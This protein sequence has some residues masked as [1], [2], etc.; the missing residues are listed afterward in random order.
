MR[1]PHYLLHSLASATGTN[2]RWGFTL[3][4]LDAGDTIA[5][6]EIEAEASSERLELLSVVRGLEALPEPAQVTLLT[7]SDTIRRGIH[8]GL[9]EWRDNDWQWESFGEMVPV[10]NLDLW[11]RIDRA[12]SYHDVEVRRWRVDPAQGSADPSPAA[13]EVLAHVV[14][15]SSTVSQPAESFADETLDTPQL[16]QPV[17]RIALPEPK[18]IVVPTVTALPD[19]VRRYRTR[20]WNSRRHWQWYWLRLRRRIIELWDS[21]AWMCEQLRGPRP[22]ADWHRFCPKQQ[23][24]RDYQTQQRQFR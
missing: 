20:W 22:D 13:L 24:N 3:R 6:S 19:R 5:V 2:A 17:R 18:V 4:P 10:K 12:L 8:F 11:R 16:R 14:Q 23:L 15:Q 1:R 9:D 21:L 7:A